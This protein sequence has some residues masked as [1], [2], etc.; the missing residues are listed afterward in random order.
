MAVVPVMC[1]QVSGFLTMHVPEFHERFSLSFENC[2]RTCIEYFLYS[3][4]KLSEISRSLI[5]SHER[6]SKSLYVSKF[7]PEIYKE[8]NCRYL[9]A[10]CFY[11]M[12][13]HAIH[14]FN[15]ADN[16][17][18]NLETDDQVFDSFYSK[19]KDFD[20]R[21]QISRP[22]HRVYLRGHYHHMPFSTSMVTHH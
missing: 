13:H 14:R 22:A 19:L 17:S 12:V 21:I 4:E 2:D 5:V 1:E 20:F 9:S 7:Y 6:F 18:I 8:I 10:S 11:I 3:K 16:C 15:L